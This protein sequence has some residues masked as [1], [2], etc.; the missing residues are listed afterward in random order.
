MM[1]WR[2]CILLGRGGVLIMQSIS[3]VGIVWTSGR[4]GQLNF[5]PLLFMNFT[6]MSVP[7][8]CWTIPAVIIM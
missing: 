8:T 7:S 6:V 3:S 4:G 5:V 1:N 2:P